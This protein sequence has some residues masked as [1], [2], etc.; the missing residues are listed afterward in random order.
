VP[1]YEHKPRIDDVKR[2]STTRIYFSCRDSDGLPVN[3]TGATISVQFVP[4]T[5]GTTVTKAGALSM[6]P[7]AEP[8]FYVDLTSTDTAANDPQLI[9]VYAT[10]TIGATIY[11]PSAFFRLL[12]STGV[13]P[14]PPAGSVY[15]SSVNGETGDVV[16]D[17]TDV[18]AAPAVHTHAIADVIGLQDALNA[19]TNSLTKTAR[20]DTASTITKGQVVYIHGSSGNNL[21]VRLADADSESTAASTIGVATANIAAGAD[22]TIL[23]AGYLEN[24]NNLPVASFANG[25]ALWLSQ[26]AGGWTTTPP[27]QPAHRVFL[28]WVITNSNGSAGRAYIKV[29][30]GQELDELHDV[31]IASKAEKDLLS[32]DATAGLWKNRTRADAGVAAS[33]HAHA[34][35]DVTGLQTALDGKAASSHVH[36]ISDVTGLQTALDGKAASSHT[37]AIADVTGLQTALDGKAPV[38][39]TSVTTANNNTNATFYPVFVSATGAGDLF[40]DSVTTP[41]TYN[42]S[43]GEIGLRRIK[44]GGATVYVSIDGPSA[45]FIFTDGTDLSSV[46]AA[47]YD[48]N[49]VAPFGFSS[50]VGFVFTAP[51][52][53]FTNGTWSYSF[54]AATPSTRQVPRATAS[55][56]LGWHTLPE[57]TYGT[58]APTGGNVGDIYVQHT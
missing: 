33:V 19:G 10:V 57:I 16:L 22:G 46:G 38:N 8:Q 40:V 42:P 2:G 39:P 18:G 55:G 51:S 37:H 48:H 30:N 6:T 53:T 7:A 41:W 43:T 34:I 17:A 54:P 20:N 23:V 3:M 36:A 47:S 24:L 28:G 52:H 35:A 26:T 56:V 4:R 13:P 5:A 44:A 15:V 1:L 12:Q 25:A 29:I 9:D 58:A 14:A 45:S 11:R 31:L 27:T 49:G 21:L 32:Y 50:N